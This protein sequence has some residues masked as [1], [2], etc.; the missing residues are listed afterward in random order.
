MNSFT[1]PGQPWNQKNAERPAELYK[2]MVAYAKQGTFLCEVR[3]D[4]LQPSSNKERYFQI[5]F[6][7]QPTG[8]NKCCVLK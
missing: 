3:D 2:K 8:R 4:F 6:W 5:S 1:E 7:K